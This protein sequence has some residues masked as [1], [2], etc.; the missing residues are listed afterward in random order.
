M[1]DND[2]GTNVLLMLFA[3]NYTGHNNFFCTIELKLVDW[4]E[5]KTTNNPP[6]GEIVVKRLVVVL[7][8]QRLRVLLTK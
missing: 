8:F 5:Y 3:N 4:L 1:V 6:R 2:A 7:K